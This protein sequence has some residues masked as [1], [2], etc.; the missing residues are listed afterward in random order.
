MAPCRMSHC[1]WRA[2]TPLQIPLCDLA[3]SPLHRCLPLTFAWVWS[4][5]RFIGGVRRWREGGPFPA[6]LPAWPQCLPDCPLECHPFWVLVPAPSSPCPCR[7]SCGTHSRGYS[8]F[9]RPL[10]SPSPVK[11]P[12]FPL[13]DAICFRQGSDWCKQEGWDVDPLDPTF[14]RGHS[15]QVPR[16]LRLPTFPPAWPL[17]MPGLRQAPASLIYLLNNMQAQ[18]PF[19]FNVSA[20]QWIRTS[21]LGFC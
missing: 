17:H 13:E 21:R 12:T 3:A 4:M 2:S 6:S 16:L 5:G 9:L 14:P 1:G 15:S 8:L 18:F 7:P 11:S 19:V 20:F 10:G